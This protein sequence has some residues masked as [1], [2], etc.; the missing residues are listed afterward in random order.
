MQKAKKYDWKDS[1]LALFGSDLE[2]NIKKA[3]AET[4]VAWKGSGQKVSAFISIYQSI[5]LSI[6]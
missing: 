2:K 4:E 5:N 1:N 6:N 3:S